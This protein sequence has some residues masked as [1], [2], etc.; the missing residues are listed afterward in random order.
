MLFVQHNNFNVLRKSPILDTSIYQEDATFSVLKF[1]AYIKFAA[2]RLSCTHLL[3]K[4][5]SF[6][7]QSS[8]CPAVQI[9][10]KESLLETTVFLSKFSK[11]YDAR[12]FSLKGNGARHGRGTHEEVSSRLASL[13][14]RPYRPFTYAMSSKV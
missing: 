10:L 14:T 8:L 1:Y 12:R 9:H 11:D 13:P 7:L 6:P 2:L 4:K 5:I 3:E